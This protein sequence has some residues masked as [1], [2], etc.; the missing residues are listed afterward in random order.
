MNTSYRTFCAYIL[1]LSVGNMHATFFKK[2]VETTSGVFKK[3]PT[4]SYALT[5]QDRFVFLKQNYPGSLQILR[6]EDARMNPDLCTQSSQSQTHLKAYY[7]SDSS[8]NYEQLLNN[9]IAERYCDPKALPP[10]QKPPPDWFYILFKSGIKTL[11]PDHKHQLVKASLLLS[12][13]EVEHAQT[14][15]AFYHGTDHVLPMLLRT[16]LRTNANVAASK[17]FFV[18]DKGVND[19]L[20]NVSDARH[21]MQQSFNEFKYRNNRTPIDWVPRNRTSFLS[22]TLSLFGGSMGSGGESAMHRLLMGTDPDARDST[23]GNEN[24]LQAVFDTHGL[25]KWRECQDTIKQSCVELD[26]AGALLQILV[27]KNLVQP[28]RIYRSGD[29]GIS[30]FLFTDLPQKLNALQRGNLK[31]LYGEYQAGSRDGLRSVDSLQ[32]RLLLDPSLFESQDSG[33]VMHCLA[34]AHE[35]NLKKTLDFF[36]DI[37]QGQQKPE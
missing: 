26:R 1:L 7:S 17:L 19:E 28:Q 37:S 18:R 12:G 4:A 32:A 36:H 6:P 25:K 10:D 3:K 34:F 2:L 35:Q 15:Y 23:I 29:F 14:H 24:R 33:V 11:S 8:S 16:I 13:Q 22:A 5:P 31:E 27:P 21:Y 30:P 9:V 20:T